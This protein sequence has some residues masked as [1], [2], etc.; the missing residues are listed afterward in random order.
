MLHRWPTCCAAYTSALMIALYCGICSSRTVSR[1]FLSESGGKSNFCNFAAVFFTSK[2]AKRSSQAFATRH[3]NSSMC[4]F[5]DLSAVL[6]MA[7]SLAASS[8]CGR[9]NA[10]KLNNCRIKHYSQVEVRYEMTGWTH[11]FSYQWNTVPVSEYGQRMRMW[12]E[13]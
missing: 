12:R 3:L 5:Q 4:S 11:C 9:K 8:S 7:M 2:T 6:F 1:A 13:G 10:T